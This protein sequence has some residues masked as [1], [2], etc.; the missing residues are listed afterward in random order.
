MFVRGTRSVTDDVN[1]SLLGWLVSRLDWLVVATLFLRFCIDVCTVYHRNCTVCPLAAYEDSI[2]C[3]CICQVSVHSLTRIPCLFADSNIFTLYSL[4]AKLV[5]CDSDYV[6][7]LLPASVSCRVLF[8]KP[9]ACPFIID[10]WK[11]TRVVVDV[12]LS[13]ATSSCCRTYF[14]Y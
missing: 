6:I 7:Y 3:F 10:C 13:A 9:D 1:V 8:R 14:Y 2:T 11:F 4:I 12:K 5:G